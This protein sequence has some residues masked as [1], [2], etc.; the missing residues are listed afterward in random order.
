MRPGR[1]SRAGRRRGFVGLIASVLAVGVTVVLFVVLVVAVTVVR[2]GAAAREPYL[3]V[4]WQA[5]EVAGRTHCSRVSSFAL[6]GKIGWN[7]Q[8]PT[9]GKLVCCSCCL[10]SRGIGVASAALLSGVAEG[11][12]VVA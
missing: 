8:P 5:C 7:A 10:Q 1:R 6:S 9:S 4:C 12:R 11:H 2:R 3:E